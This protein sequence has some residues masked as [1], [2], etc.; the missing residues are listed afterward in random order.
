LS[1]LM[2]LVLLDSLSIVSLSFSFIGTN[3]AKS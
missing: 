1:L 3:A 2:S